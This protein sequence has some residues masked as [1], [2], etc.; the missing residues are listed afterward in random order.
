MSMRGKDTLKVFVGDAHQYFAE[1]REYTLSYLRQVFRKRIKQCENCKDPFE[2]FP[3]LV[4]RDR[5]GRYWKPK[6][7][8][9]LVPEE[10]PE[11]DDE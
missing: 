1:G 2:A 9:H 11:E 3:G 6:L 10:R 5:Q 7:E 8:V 4:L